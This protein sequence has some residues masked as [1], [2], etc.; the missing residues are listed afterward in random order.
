MSLAGLIDVAAEV[1]RLE[2]QS[3]EKRKLLDVTK[4]KLSNERFVSRAPA[5]VVQQQKE[6]VADLENQ[7]HVIEGNIA[8]LR[9][10]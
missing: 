4:G 7:L 2:K 9:A 1:K 8:E 6:L 10:A 3:A 5:E